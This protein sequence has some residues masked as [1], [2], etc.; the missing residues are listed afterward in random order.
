MNSPQYKSLIRQIQEY[1][2]Q[3]QCYVEEDYP[4]TL[5][6]LENLT[7]TELREW[8][9]RRIT[10]LQFLIDDDIEPGRNDCSFKS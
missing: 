2:K 4:K 6:E 5:E 10:E 3:I 7:M 8:L 9:D 1:D